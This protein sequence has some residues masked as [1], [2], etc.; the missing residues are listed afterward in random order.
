VTVALVA[1]RPAAALALLA[2]STAALAGPLRRH[3]V[4]TSEVVH[5]SARAAG[6]TLVGVGR[7]LTVVAGPVV[8]VGILRRWRWSATAAGLVALPPLVDWWRRRPP[9][10]PLR[11]SL[12]SVADDSAYGIGVWWGCLR[13]RSLDPLLPSVRSRRLGP[14]AGVRPTAAR[15]M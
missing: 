3:G 11:W 15:E 12:A 6:W 5:R 10:D 7:A 9:I 14:P 1:R 4:P 2:G 8:A 13:A